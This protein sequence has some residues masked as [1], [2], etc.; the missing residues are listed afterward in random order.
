MQD[1][2]I[3]HHCASRHNQAEDRAASGTCASNWSTTA[4]SPD[5]KT[6][7][8]VCVFLYLG[9]LVLVFLVVGGRR[10]K[11]LQITQQ[12]YWARAVLL[13]RLHG[14]T[15]THHTLQETSGRVISPTQ[16]PLPQ[17]SLPT[18]FEPAIPASER[19]QTHAL[20]SAAT[21][22]GEGVTVQSQGISD[23]EVRLPYT[24]HL[25]DCLKTTSNYLFVKDSVRTS[26]RTQCVSIMYL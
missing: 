15:Q 17:H 4:H 3:T 9:I 6:D 2:P 12:P 13:S 26:Q 8:N 21:G 22:I 25:I 23:A 24:V 5:S 7:C 19:P 1:W 20:D 11:F 14:H 18:E 10:C 16:K